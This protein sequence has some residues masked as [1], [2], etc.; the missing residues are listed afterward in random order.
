MHKI[1]FVC[2]GNICRS[3]MAEYMMKDIVHRKGIDKDYYIVS[4]GTS[5]EEDG[6]DLYPPV[7]ELLDEKNI[8]Y[9]KHRATRLEKEDYNLYDV[10]YCMEESNRNRAIQILGGDPYHKVKLLL[11]R[12]IAD[13]WY[14]RDFQKAYDDIL[15]GLM[16]II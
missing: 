3:P 1:C 5:Y 4:R 10:F 9:S 13:P 12:D 6:N 11:D 16:K 7:K 2:L 8:L 15:E 14:T